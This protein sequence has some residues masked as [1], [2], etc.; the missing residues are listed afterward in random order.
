MTLLTLYALIGATMSLI[1]S[2]GRCPSASLAVLWPLAL[3]AIV[4][5]VIL[6]D[7]EVKE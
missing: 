1:E 7:A 3:V 2:Q 5:G 6:G 4:G